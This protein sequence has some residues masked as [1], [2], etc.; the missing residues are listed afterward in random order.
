MTLTRARLQD[1]LIAR[2]GMRIRHTR[3]FRVWGN[4]TRSKQ[5]RMGCF[6]CVSTSSFESVRTSGSNAEPSKRPRKPKK[7]C[8]CAR[9]RVCACARAS[10]S[11]SK[12][13]RKDRLREQD[14]AVC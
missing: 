4:L 5:S 11:G 10:C 12:G 13:E 8:V 3:K 6:V 7:V 1:E 9:V 14:K 2:E